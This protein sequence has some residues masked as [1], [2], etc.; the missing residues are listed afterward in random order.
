MKKNTTVLRNLTKWALSYKG[1]KDPV[2]GRTLVRGVPLLVIDDEADNASINTRAVPLDEMGNAIDEYNPTKIN[3]LIRTLLHSFET[4]IYVGYTATPFANIFIYKDIDSEMYG[5]D[6]FPRSF[7]TNLAPPSSY[8]GPVDVFGMDGDSVAGLEE[9]PALPV[10]RPVSDYEPWLPDR[11]KKDQTLN[12]P[13][14]ESLR[15]ALQS[16]ILVCATRAMRA[17]VNSNPHNTMLIHITRFVNV[18]NL[19][20]NQVREELLALQR[21]LRYGSGNAPEKLIDKLRKIWQDDF[22]ATTRAFA[23]DTKFSDEK[24]LAVPWEKLE[25]FIEPAAAKIETRVINGSAKDSLVYS[26]HPAG[27]SVIAIGGDKLSRGL[28]LEAL[29]VS[30]Y[31]RATRMYDTLMQMGRWFGYRPGYADLCRLYT[32][33]ELAGWYR[34][35]TAADEELRLE[36]KAMEEL[37][38]T[39]EEYGLRV[40]SHPGG[41]MVT[42]AAKMRG[43]TP[44]ELSFSKTLNQP[45]VFSLQPEDLKHNFDLT[46]RFLRTLGT[47]VLAKGTSGTV[48][49]RTRDPHV[50]VQFLEA[51]ST[52]PDARRFQPKVLADYIRQRVRDDGELGEWV[53]A[54]ISS[55]AGSEAG[56][57]T[58]VGG[59][60]VNTVIRSGTVS[61]DRFQ[62]KGIT[63]PSDESLDLTEDEYSKALQLTRGNT[64]SQTVPVRPSSFHIKRTRPPTRG[65]LLLYPVYPEG[66][67]DALPVMGLA[68]SFPRSESGERAVVP[69]VVNN[70]YWRQEYG[71]Q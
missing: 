37:K 18:Q 65:L 64:S 5:E 23:G 31:L 57:V 27:V 59:V 52:H 60:T 2:S 10:L 70:T 13:L 35:I 53:V 50:I 1:E 4:S 11:H 54:L 66:Y 62:V 42:A 39:P 71:E 26:E 24:Y 68:V 20:E 56:K 14:P 47:H 69:Y 22:C 8:V 44:V 25:P 48:L 17:G 15:R 63:S 29:S 49:W 28:T 34:D 61:R 38:S 46:N 43:G 32:T 30:Y 51:F 3:G 58:T 21:E 41:L 19:I 6:L 45:T 55:G 33:D 40:R 16:F 67:E 12:T 9:H 7:I 36:F